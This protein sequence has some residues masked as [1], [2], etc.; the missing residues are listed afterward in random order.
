MRRE[1]G[2]I[3]LT[4]DRLVRWGRAIGA[5]ARPPVWISL[6][7]PLGAGKSVFARA[8]CEGAGV[9][10]YLPSPG[11]T[12]LNV[13]RSPRSF[14]VVHADLYRIER[15]GE[16]DALGWRDL[17]GGDALVLIEW[18]DRAAGRQPSDRWDLTLEHLGDPALRRVRG[19]A[20]GAAPDLPAPQ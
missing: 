14:P 19:V 9:A 12:L 11:F 16:L 13:Y 17:E 7:G 3:D 8:V 10:G 20:L 6:Y 5:Q 4:E 18:A 15:P 1:I 2:P